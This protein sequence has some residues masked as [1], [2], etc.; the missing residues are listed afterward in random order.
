MCPLIET[1][2]RRDLTWFSISRSLRNISERSWWHGTFS[3]YSGK[4]YFRYWINSIF[5]IRFI[6][7]LFFFSRKPLGI[8]FLT[9]DDL[10]LSFYHNII[11][12]RCTLV[13][14]MHAALLN[15]II[16]D[17][18]QSKSKKR[19]PIPRVVPALR[20]QINGPDDMDIDDRKSVL[21]SRDVLERFAKT[22]DKKVISS[23]DSRKGWECVLIGCLYQVYIKRFFNVS[24]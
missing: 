14:E 1:Y 7:L 5:I 13:I 24:I 22:W 18:L 17:R 11:Q 4:F 3:Q 23:K 12:P 15:A 16:R 6:L 19:Q 21:A 8:S 20:D 2:S 10:E 9:L